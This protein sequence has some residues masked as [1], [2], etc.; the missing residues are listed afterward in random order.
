M[1]LPLLGPETPDNSPSRQGAEVPNEPP[2]EAEIPQAD[3]V[4]LNDRELI[5][6]T[7]QVAASFLPQPVRDVIQKFKPIV[8][9]MDALSLV[10][11]GKRAASRGPSSLKV[12]KPKKRSVPKISERKAVPEHITQLRNASPTVNLVPVVDKQLSYSDLEYDRE[13]SKRG[14]AVKIAFASEDADKRMMYWQ[15]HGHCC[16]ICS[17]VSR[18]MF[19]ELQATSRL[20]RDDRKTILALHAWGQLADEFEFCN[21]WAGLNSSDP[22]IFMTETVDL[23]A[24]G[25]YVQRNLPRS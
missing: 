10:P 4:V 15:L 13:F 7:V 1:I 14:R 16:T 17:W 2:T 21:V 20:P 25:E 24:F 11:D 23:L 3:A 12:F 5:D 9:S 18:F 8:E 6:T 22:P 19:S